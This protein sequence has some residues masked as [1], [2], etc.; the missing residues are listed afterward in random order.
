VW[1]WLPASTAVLIA[2]TRTGGPSVESTCQHVNFYV[3]AQEAEAWLD[4]HARL[5]GRVLDQSTAIE[6]AGAVSAG[7]LDAPNPVDAGS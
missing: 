4:G 7:L 5:T 6:L 3:T 2:Q 1:R